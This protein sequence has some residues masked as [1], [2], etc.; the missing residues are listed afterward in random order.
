MLH[1]LARW[2][3]PLGFLAAVAAFALARPTW[4]SLA[5]GLIVAL[6]GEVLR[7]WAA[8][9]IHKSR[10]ITRSG[11]YRFVRHPLYL[12]SVILGAGF[13][14]AS[15]SL[16]VSALVAAYLVMTLLAATRTEEAT[17]DEKFAGEY[18]A[19]R[20]G[21][22]TPV[23]R[24]FDWSQVMANKEYRAIIGFVA[25]FIVLAVIATVTAHA[26]AQEPATGL[27]L[28]ESIPSGANFDKAEFRFWLPS[29]SGA[30]KG[31]VVLMP[32]SN[33]DGRSMAADVFWQDFAVKNHVA[34]VASRFTD[35]PH[36]QS[37]IEDY[38]Q[39][40]RGSGQALLDAIAKFAATS[41]HAE[42]ATV[43]LLLWGMSAG[44]QFNYEF[45]AWKPER[46]GAF[47]VNKGGIY[48]SALLP[49]AA[50]EVPGLLFVGDKDLPS[51]V[52]TIT[53]LFA[54]NRRGG[55][56][57]ALVVEPGAA[58]V[59]GKSKELGA[60]LFEEALAGA[61]PGAGF[62]GNLQAQTFQPAASPG[63]PSAPNAWFATERL[64]KAWQAVVA[65]K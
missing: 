23:A 11:P 26:A 34:L 51:R 14:V 56:R 30:V 47:I 42:V 32:G 28:D 50:R 2:R 33:G 1:R 10:E 13:A 64:A 38:V 8:G 40:S 49:K 36:D 24:R 6:P 35:K 55:A 18:S 57:W 45:V 44:G 37:F 59:V 39:V 3:V 54:V 41:R 17:L 46:V 15:H 63:T 60:L 22:A 62:I 53:G 65:G 31:V 12:G 4:R 29:P 16:V 25:A 7:I 20:E 43:P 61:V 9:H 27:T 19:Y 5:A 48:Y 58:H 21:R 52:E